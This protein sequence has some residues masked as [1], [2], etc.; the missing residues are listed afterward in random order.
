MTPVIL[1]TSFF[2]HSVVRENTRVWI[3]VE[4]RITRSMVRF[5][6]CIGN[7]QEE[8]QREANIGIGYVCWFRRRW[9]T[10]SSKFPF[11]RVAA[12]ISLINSWVIL[13]FLM[14]E[15]PIRESSASSPIVGEWSFPS[16]LSVWVAVAQ[17][18]HSAC[19]TSSH[20]SCSSRSPGSK[21]SGSS[22]GG[23]SMLSCRW[24]KVQGTL[25][26]G[27]S[28]GLPWILELISGWSS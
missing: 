7:G 16:W 3:M 14:R 15:M 19:S 9:M 18:C 2:F 11:S 20:C 23:L 8:I 5:L 4:D 26:M 10:S 24:C 22:S 21:S 17:A 12:H 25:W 1:A 13:M 6:R 28:S 27:K